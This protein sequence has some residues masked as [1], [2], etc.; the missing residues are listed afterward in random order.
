MFSRLQSI[1]KQTVPNFT[2]IVWSK[3]PA[4]KS[5]FHLSLYVQYR[6]KKTFKRYLKS[7]HTHGR[8]D[9]QTHRRTFQLIESIGPEGRCFEKW[10]LFELICAAYIVTLNSSLCSKMVQI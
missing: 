2:D 6:G 8:T 7:E 5:G 9:G 10:R 4:V 1:W 3:K